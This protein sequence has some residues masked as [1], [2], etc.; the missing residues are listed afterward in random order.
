MSLAVL[1]FGCLLSAAA[2]AAKLLQSTW[3]FSN[4][5][6]LFF[7]TVNDDAQKFLLSASHPS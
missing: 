5:P 2:A 6:L 4:V 7:G 3:S 1:Q